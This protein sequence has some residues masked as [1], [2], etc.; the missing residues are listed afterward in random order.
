MIDEAR[1]DVQRHLADCRAVL[2]G[3]R[4]VMRSVWDEHASERDRRLLLMLGGVSGAMLSRH[5]D[6][7]WC[8]LPADRRSEVIRGLRR[9]AVW[10]D[11]LGVSL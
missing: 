1:M 9:F 6:A 3:D 11:R 5:A 10:A 8:D 2:G 7:P 4:S